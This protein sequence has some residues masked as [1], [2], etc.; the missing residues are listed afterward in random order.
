MVSFLVPQLRMTLPSYIDMFFSL[1]CCG[2]KRAILPRPHNLFSTSRAPTSSTI[3]AT[4]HPGSLWLFLAHTPKKNLLGFRPF[5]LFEIA[6][7]E[8]L[9][10]LYWHTPITLVHCPTI[11]SFFFLANKNSLGFLI[12]VLESRKSS[13]ISVWILLQTAGQS[14]YF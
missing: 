14:R 5:F 11:Y 10:C 7:V 3:F 6:L 9:F 13:L 4:H 2:T 8:M 1:R 12:D